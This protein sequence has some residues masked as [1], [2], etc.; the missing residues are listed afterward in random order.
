MSVLLIAGMDIS[1]I[2]IEWMTYFLA[3]HPEHQKKL[4][5][6]IDSFDP[7]GKEWS[8]WNQHFNFGK[9]LLDAV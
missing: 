8:D 1:T 6:E 2:A 3:K 4:L 9:M 7:N 5:D